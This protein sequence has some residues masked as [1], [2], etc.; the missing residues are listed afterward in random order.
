M[1]YGGMGLQSHRF[2]DWYKKVSELVQL[3]AVD[4]WVWAGQWLVRIDPENIQGG[5]GRITI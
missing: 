5:S 1:G 4:D 3:L 2:A